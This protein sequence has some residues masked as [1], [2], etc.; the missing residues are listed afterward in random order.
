VFDSPAGAA[1]NSNTNLFHTQLPS[2][3]SGLQ[4]LPLYLRR[5]DLPDK[6]EQANAKIKAFTLKEWVQNA[7]RDIKF[8]NGDDV[9]EEEN[10]PFKKT[11][12]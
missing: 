10:Y 3:R 6:E 5:L 2:N 11:T 9:T 7:I 12:K 8:Y 4:N 1:K